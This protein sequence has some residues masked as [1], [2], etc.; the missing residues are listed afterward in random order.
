MSLPGVL[1]PRGSSDRLMRAV[2]AAVG[3]AC[4]SAL[5]GPWSLRQPPRDD[6]PV[7]MRSG[8]WGEPVELAVLVL[9]VAQD[10]AGY[11]APSTPAAQV[12]PS[13]LSTPA[14]LHKLSTRMLAWFKA[15][16]RD[17]PSGV[18]TLLSAAV[19]AGAL[20]AET[21]GVGETGGITVETGGLTQ[22]ANKRFEGQRVRERF[23]DN[24]ILHSGLSALAAT[25]VGQAAV[26]AE[27][28]ARLTS[29]HPHT[30]AAAGYLSALIFEA[31]H[32]VKDQPV[33]RIRPHLASSL[34]SELERPLIQEA[35][36]GGVRGAGLSALDALA[37]MHAA[38]A[39]A[40]EES[41]RNPRLNPV[42]VGV[43][44]A[45]RAGGDSAT[46]AALTGAV[47]GA[48][49]GLAAI[50]AEWL[51]RIHGWPGFNWTGLRDLAAG[52]FQA[53]LETPSLGQ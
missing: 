36:G 9:E 44:A 25:N 10:E 11:S 3:A 14:G 30:V 5:A 43:E 28:V 23:A 24:L 21:G 38:L 4:G 16:E 29:A 12:T 32:S 31:I 47:L 51:E 33:A 50:P 35:I 8:R 13:G 53:R 40:V 34:V 19:D 52:A 6:E 41:E 18:Q 26:A 48:V 27:S 39:V 46:V 42:Q 45:V 2:G 37:G 1:V 17:L 15:G 49:W 20:A 22:L 7:R